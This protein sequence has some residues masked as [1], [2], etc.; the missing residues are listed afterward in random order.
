MNTVALAPLDD[1]EV[2]YSKVVLTE[3][4]RALVRELADAIG[5]SR[6]AVLSYL[7]SDAIARVASVPARSRAKEL[8]ST[9]LLLKGQD[10]FM[11]GVVRR[12]RGPSLAFITSSLDGLL[13]LARSRYDTLR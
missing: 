2:F 6:S 8:R 3:S 11:Q 12:A 7:L 5:C 13:T 9:R 10:D 1:A 4:E